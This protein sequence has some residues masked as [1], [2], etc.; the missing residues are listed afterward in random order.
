[1]GCGRSQHEECAEAEAGRRTC[2]AVNRL[3]ESA[4]AHNGR[5]HLPIKNRAVYFP[6]SA[7]ARSRLG[8]EEILRDLDLEFGRTK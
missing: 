8:S 3:D 6:I 1:V 4:A 2:A 5:R 7:P